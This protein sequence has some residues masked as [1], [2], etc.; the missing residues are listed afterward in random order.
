MKGQN[1]PRLP[2]TVPYRQQGEST[3]GEEEN[4]FLD[5]FAMFFKKHNF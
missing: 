1:Q 5:L 3:V 2:E 4:V